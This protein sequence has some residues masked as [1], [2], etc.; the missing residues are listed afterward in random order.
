MKKGLKTPPHRVEA[1]DFA[2][3]LKAIED[4]GEKH[5]FKTV[6]LIERASDFQS[7]YTFLE[8]YYKAMRQ[9]GRSENVPVADPG[10]LLA[11]N[12]SHKLFLDFVH[13]TEKGNE[14]IARK[15]FEILIESGVLTEALDRAAR[16]KKIEPPGIS[17]VTPT[18][19]TVPPGGDFSFMPASRAQITAPK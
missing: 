15:I 16:E 18:Q 10:S 3:N 14:L 4:L 8:K 6:F 12:D 7:K 13:P 2:A 5:G 1:A 19:I 17:A 11:H 9:V